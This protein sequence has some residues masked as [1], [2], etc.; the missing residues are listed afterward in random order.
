[1]KTMD[2]LI[3]SLDR[4]L[5]DLRI[6][7]ID[8]CNF[9]CAYCMPE[10]EYAHRSFLNREELLS[11]QEI[12]RI[13]QA[14]ALL[15]V[16]KLRIT[17]GE[18]LLRKNLPDL[19]N[20]L[21]GISGINDIALT[22]NGYYLPLYSKYLKE[23]GLK[24]VN[25]SLDAME[26]SIFTKMNGRNVKVSSILKGIFAAKEAGLEVKINM[27]VQ[28][29]VNDHQI[30]P[31]VQFFKEND[32]TLRFIE[33]MDAGNSNGWKL[34]QVVTIKEIHDRIQAQYPLE[35]VSF[36]YYGEV[37]KRY[38]HVGTNAEIGYISSVSDAFCS[39]CTRV[40]LSADGKIYKCLF[41]NQ[42]FDI[43]KLMR[44]GASTGQIVASVKDIWKGRTDRYSEDRVNDTNQE[45]KIEMYYIGG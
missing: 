13:V 12:E 38:R 25:I 16:N 3:D 40:R 34:D 14:F 37:A 18:P 36:R 26:D 6:S 19:I 20:K 39:T 32:M 43:K 42:G 2:N 24:R 17:G 1:M 11:F 28:K 5:R 30:I 44:E 9:R 8:Q 33:F 27:V 45:R 29:N 22:T 7:V 4:P 21:S 35:Q 31:M 23:A 15:G 41:A 10:K